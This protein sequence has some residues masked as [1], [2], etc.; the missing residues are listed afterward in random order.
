MKNKLS[1]IF[2]TLILINISM[3]L[4]ETN[5]AE[6][7]T[8]AVIGFEGQNVSSMDAVVVSGFLRTSLV[9]MN[10]YK[11]VDRKN[12][13]NLLAEQGFQMTGCTTEECAVKMGKI[14]NVNKIIIG[15][16]SKLMGVYYVTANVVDV[17]TGQITISKRVKSA[18]GAGLADAVDEL[19]GKLVYPKNEMKPVLSQPQQN[20]PTQ[21]SYTP[22]EYQKTGVVQPANKKSK[23][24]NL[25]V[26]LF[27]G[28]S[29][30]ELDLTFSN[31]RR[32]IHESELSM[33]FHYGASYPESY[34]E[35]SFEKLQAA[36]A[37]T[38]MGIRFGFFGNGAGVGIELSHS[39]LSTIDQDALATYDDYL[40]V[41]FDFRWAKEYITIKSLALAVDFFLSPGKTFRPYIG[42]GVGLTLNRVHSDYI[43]QW[44][45]VDTAQEVFQKPLDQFAPGFLFRIPIGVRL[46]FDKSFGFFGEYRY[47]LNYF[48]FDR[49]IADESDSIKL[50]MKQFLFGL[51]FEF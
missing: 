44:Y 13:E 36:S 9:N 46:M 47:S 14:L 29:S 38:P 23:D 10:V 24:N 4:S 28:S 3:A 35:I 51:C 50:K 20:K 2:I 37:S 39:S 41:D 48:K 40:E 19:A 1:I 8:V 5:K 49:N 25:Y 16:L 12:M 34:D 33:D 26:D 45:N 32:R 15:D 31:T 11:I 6:Q 43:S 17:E 18:T 30:G 21:V 22:A 7:I 42:A 27:V